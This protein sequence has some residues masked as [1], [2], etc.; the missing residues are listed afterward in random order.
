MKKLIYLSNGIIPSM[1]ANSVH[2]M[3]M[4]NAFSKN[5]ETI[6]IGVAS[7]SKSDPSDFYGTTNPFALKLIK[8][9]KGILGS[10]IYLF[11]ILTL[12]A[13]EKT[14]LFYGRHTIALFLLSKM[15]HRVAYESHQMPQNRFRCF[16][17][18]SMFRQ[19]K[20]LKL[21]VIS[22]ALKK[23]YMRQFLFLK[24]EMVVV[25][26]DAA[27][28]PM[29][30][31]D[32]NKNKNI[33]V[34]YVGH[35]YAG[36]GIELILG[37]AKR[38]PSLS[39]E[40]VGGQ[41]E[42]VI[43]WKDKSVNLPNV[44]FRGHAQPKDL[45]SYYA[46]F[47]IVLAPYQLGVNQ[48]DEKTDTT[49]WMS[50]MKIFEYM[51]FGLPIICSDIPVLREILNKNNAI[52]VSPSNLDAWCTALD[53]LQNPSLRKRLGDNAHETVATNYTWEIRAKKILNA[54]L[55]EPTIKT[56]V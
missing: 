47:D 12:V 54:V 55:S 6:L 5:I 14:A 23:D 7:E 9:Y 19:K 15:D 33:V 51:A 1:S 37:M 20:F 53:Q 41:K 35:L 29:I 16:L 18:A 8:K 50:P 2:V 21:V 27:D 36:R 22:Q 49:K 10:L 30:T 24:D 40:L 43:Y 44:V 3:K 38:R 52:L 42:D 31:A 32:K 25:S 39:F 46:R 17:E 11:R 4:C 26:H 56:S 13:R 34:G 48:G 45:H 28:L